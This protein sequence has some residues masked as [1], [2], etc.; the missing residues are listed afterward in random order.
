[1]FT[2]PKLCLT[3]LCVI[4]MMHGAAQQNRLSPYHESPGVQILQIEPQLPVEGQPV[5]IYFR[6]SN[7]SPGGGLVL[8]GWVGAEINSGT[9]SP[10]QSAID[11]PVTNLANNQWVD[12]AIN[13]VA[14]SAGMQRTIRLFF[15]QTQSRAS[16]ATLTK[17]APQY[18]VGDR[19]TDI[20]CYFLFSLDKFIVKHTRARTTDTDYGALY[21]TLNG[22]PAMQP[23]GVFLGNFKNGTFPMRGT[24]A[25][26]KPV[27][28]ISAPISVV[29]GRA[30]SL[31]VAYSIYNGGGIADQSKF[32][33]SMAQALTTPK[34]FD[35]A[36]AGHTNW[37]TAV[38]VLNPFFNILGGCDG[39]TALDSITRDISGFFLS[40]Q[41]TSQSFERDFNSEAYASQT[42]C[43]N[44]SN[45][46]VLSSVTRLTSDGIGQAA[47]NQV[48]LSAELL[49]GTGSN[50][51]PSVTMINRYVGPGSQVTLPTGILWQS[52]QTLDDNG[53]FMN[54]SDPAY[55]YI[56]GTI[57]QAPA[58]WTKPLL[59]VLR[60]AANSNQ[61][62]MENNNA[63]PVSSTYV[64]QLVK[65]NL[66]LREVYEPGKA[67]E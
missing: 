33:L 7:N 46:T 49:N 53:N 14:P 24:D 57:Y 13:V 54:V 51:T 42:G 11:W 45:Y 40:T 66:A 29:P 39:L 48:A 52:I 64:L 62:Q 34:L 30:A 60:G 28:L 44:T 43:G 26:G 59:V 21:A 58:Q 35:G 18:G 47:V 8:N 17:S 16:D 2:T 10:S 50:I 36:G 31:D 15:Y 19:M 65:Q 32:I 37:E 1:M 63:P 20:A 6:F 4:A 41:Q 22:Q 38:Q 3:S 5:T 12:G 27:S 25:S 9:S 23:L 55:G 61:P 56:N 67:K